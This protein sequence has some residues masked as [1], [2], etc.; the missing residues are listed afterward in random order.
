MAEQLYMA[1]ADAQRTVAFDLLLDG[2]GQDLGSA[3]VECHMYNITTRAV[4]TVT[5]V[6]A[7]ADQNTY[8]GRCV[9]E[10]TAAQLLTG[11]YTL[12]WE[13]TIGGKIVTYPGNAADRPFLTVRTQAA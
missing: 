5:D 2:V 10:F 3:T 13:S 1:S 11:V 6:T 7:E 12:E 4:T 8:P 9:T